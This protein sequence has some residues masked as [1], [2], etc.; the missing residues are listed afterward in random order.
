MKIKT[1][2]VDLDAEVVSAK[3]LLDL[4]KSSLQ[5][6]ALGLHPFELNPEI[7]YILSC[8]RGSQATK[9]TWLHLPPKKMIFLDNSVIYSVIESASDVETKF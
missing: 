4:K 6:L 2:M 8:C 7:L 9:S 3:E 5:I 1:K